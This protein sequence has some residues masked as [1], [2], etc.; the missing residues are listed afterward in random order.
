VSYRSE[1]AKRLSRDSYGFVFGFNSFI[2]LFLHTLMTYGVVQG[3]VI[4]V[5]TTQQV[6]KQFNKTINVVRG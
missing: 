2:A 4:S 3:H 1:V 5:S 6:N